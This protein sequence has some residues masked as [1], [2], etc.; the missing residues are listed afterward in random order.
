MASNTEIAQILI[1]AL[2]ANPDLVET[3]LE[4]PYT[5]VQEAT[6]AEEKLDKEDMSEV[7]TTAAGLASGQDFDMSNIGSLA[8]AFLGV[9]DNSVHSLVGS[10]FGGGQTQQQ[11][12]APAVQETNNANS[13]LDLGTL[14]SFAGIASQLMGGSSSSSA[15]GINLSDGIGLD[16]I[17]GLMGMTG[18]TSTQQTQQQTYQQQTT[19]QESPGGFLSSIISAI[20][21]LFTGR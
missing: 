11:A 6:G 10:L 4:H 15:G 1:E 7:V 3:F 14:V 5:A 18:G 8:S 16:D 17:V 9:S 13:G 2:K 19:Q 20:L 21:S 12:A